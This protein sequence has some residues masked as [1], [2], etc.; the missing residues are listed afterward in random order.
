MSVP[1]F[2]MGRYLLLSESDIATANGSWEALK[3]LGA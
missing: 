3:A 1:L 2:P